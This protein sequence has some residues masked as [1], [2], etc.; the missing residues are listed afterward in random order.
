MTALLMGKQ[1]RNGQ[2]G[3]VR[4]QPTGGSSGKQIVPHKNALVSGAELDHQF[5]FLVMRQKSNIHGRSLLL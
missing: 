3:M 2:T 5:F 1:Q 4:D